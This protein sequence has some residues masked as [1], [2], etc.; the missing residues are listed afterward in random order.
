MHHK[1]SMEVCAMIYI[2]RYQDC[3]D[4]FISFAVGGEHPRLCRLQS[5]TL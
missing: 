5:I 4:T 3:K 1:I 2:K